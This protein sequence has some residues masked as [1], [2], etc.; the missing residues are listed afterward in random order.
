MTLKND[1]KFKEKPTCSFKYDIRN[2]VNF[3][4]NTQKSENV[5]SIGPFYIYFFVQTVK[6]WDKKKHRGVIFCDTDQ[7]WKIWVNL[8]EYGAWGV[9]WTFIETLKSLKISNL[10]ASF[11]PRRNASARRFQR[12]CVMTLKVDAKLAWKLIRDLKNDKDF[13]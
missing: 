9:R 1:A 5:T 10:M 2:L 7:W 6:V 11:C 4:P 12:N 8:E 13:V 3:H